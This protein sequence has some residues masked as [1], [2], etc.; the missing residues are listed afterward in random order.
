MS[1]INVFVIHY[2]ALQDRREF[3][4]NFLESNCLAKWVTEK[5]I[6]EVPN[7]LT[8]SHG[9]F[10]LSDRM[11]G[12]HLGT[13]SRSLSF[14]RRK[15]YRDG[16]LL[17]LASYIHPRRLDLVTGSIPDKKKL[18]NSWLEVQEMHFNALV[19]A[20]KSDAEWSLILEDDALPMNDWAQMVERI[21]KCF[22]TEQSIWINLN[23]GAGLS[24]TDSD[25][26][27][28]ENGLFR[29]K[30]PATRCSTAY[31]VNRKFINQFIEAIKEHGMPEWIPIDVLFHLFCVKY[32]VKTYWQEPV[33]FVQGSE[34]GKFE[35]NFSKWR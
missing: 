29:V 7:R 21:I 20:R 22:P 26:K 34:N 13:N 35:S 23:S 27:P 17:H 9:V 14:T 19:L 28:D 18:R 12:L 15:A 2:S 24:R 16:L 10:G 25:P 8:S 33:T 1:H 11:I 6:K 31:L 30:P 32:R 5:E 3:L 4:S